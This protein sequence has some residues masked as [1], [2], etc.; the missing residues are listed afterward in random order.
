MN[1]EFIMYV[2]TRCPFCLKA[3]QLLSKS[4][5][6]RKVIPFDENQELLEHM[7]WAYSHKTVPMIFHKSDSEIK[8][9]GGYTDLVSYLEENNGTKDTTSDS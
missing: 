8:F 9:V 7:K 4:N 3:E 5:I 6:K 1:G 2:R